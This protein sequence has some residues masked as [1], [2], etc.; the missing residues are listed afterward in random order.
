M[1]FVWGILSVT[2]FAM[3]EKKTHFHHDICVNV[4]V[5]ICQLSMFQFLILQA[6]VSI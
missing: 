3:L 2:T 5:Y 4:W 6:N 1:G